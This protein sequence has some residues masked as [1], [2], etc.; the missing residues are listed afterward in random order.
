MR[1]LTRDA[2][3][4]ARVQIS[5]AFLFMREGIPCQNFGG[6]SFFIVV[7]N[8]HLSIINSFYMYQ[9]QFSSRGDIFVS[10]CPYYL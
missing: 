1:L 10:Y 7:A 8:V 4:A 9:I 3:R 2:L 5:V 6:V